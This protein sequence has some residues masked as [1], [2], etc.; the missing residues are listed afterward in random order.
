MGVEPGMDVL[1]YFAASGYYSELLARSVGP[2][3]S[4]IVYNN[5]EYAQFSGE[6]LVKRFENNR[7][8]NAKVLT[9][10]TNALMLEANS[11]D[12]VLFVMSYH[13]LYW[14]PKDA[15][16]PMGDPAQV[17]AGLFKAVKPGGVVVVVD[18][19][20][21]KGGDTAKVVDSLHRIDGD[22]VKSDFAN[23]GFVFDGESNAL[24]HSDDDRSKLVFDEAV[25]HKTDQFIY[26]FR[27][28][29]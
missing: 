16:A 13:D 21:A 3:G 15:K 12:G 20:A 25:R 19:A 2:A 17:T 28:P 5:P 29:K 27:K 10:P 18:H 22:V 1:D 26:R 9:V 7:L 23:A 8:P 6:K 4:V 14:V 11:L 24:Q